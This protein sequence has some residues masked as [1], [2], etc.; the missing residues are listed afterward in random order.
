MAVVFLIILG[1]GLVQGAF[2]LNTVRS[3]FPKG[4]R[5]SRF[6]RCLSSFQIAPII[7][8]QV[9]EIW[10]F[11]M[12]FLPAEV[13]L[14]LTSTKGWI[15]IFIAFYLWINMVFNY[16]AA[17]I[18]SPGYPESRKEFEGDVDIDVRDE[19]FCSKCDR[20][21][22][23]GTHHCS[24]CGTC[25]TYMSHH[26][27]FT[28]NCIGLN[29]YSYFYLFQIYCTL[30]LLFASYCTY[31]SFMAC[32]IYDSSNRHLFF[33]RYSTHVCN[34]LGDY[35]VLFLV[36]ILLFLFMIM[37]F[38]YHTMLLLADLSMI[39][40]LRLFQTSSSLWMLLK[41]MCFRIVGRKKFL[42]RILLLN[43]RKK[44]WKFLLPVINEVDDHWHG[45]ELPI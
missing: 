41:I 26:C 37:V 45:Q 15:L 9:A 42:M 38:C 27:P 1:V 7:L 43:H 25:V 24:T 6:Q 11:V 30:G 21:R 36:A 10:F 22:Y 4:G 13:D 29:N 12:V 23:T 28:N 34:E 16:L 5:K 31:N 3:M 2:I 33:L 19:D 14:P 8:I 39:E 32:M 17:M 44:I 18:V 20:V 40:F 35:P